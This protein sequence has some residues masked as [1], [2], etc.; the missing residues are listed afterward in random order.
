MEDD[1]SD[2]TRGSIPKE[3][4]VKLGGD[5][6]CLG[7][8]GGVVPDSEMCG[9]RRKSR[10][11]PAPQVVCRHEFVQNVYQMGA[12]GTRLPQCT[13]LYLFNTSLRTGELHASNMISLQSF[14]RKGVS[15]GYV[16]LN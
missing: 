3:K 8:A 4:L 10:V 2:F 6:R 14:L 5:G 11:S 7:K 16:G 15:L 9:M 1:L 12:F 13:N